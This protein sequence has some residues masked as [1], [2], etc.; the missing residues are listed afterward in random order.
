LQLEQKITQ[1]EQEKE[2][3][4]NQLIHAQKIESLGRLAGG[5]AHDF[6][7]ILTGI[8]G[9]SELALMQLDKDNPVTNDVKAIHK[10]GKRAE[11]LTRQL[12]TFSRKQVL[13]KK[14]VNLNLLVE[15]LVK[16]LTRMIGADILL[17][18]NLLNNLPNIFADTGQ[19]EQ[20]IM[21]LAVNARD[22]MP[23]GGKL[24]IETSESALTADDVKDIK[25]M[26]PG[27]YLLLTVKDNGKGMNQEIMEKIFEP[28]FTTKEVG[29][30]TGL[31]MSTVFGIIKQHQGHIKIDSEPNKGTTF[32]I[33]LPITSDIASHM[34]I[35]ENIQASGG[36]ETIMVVDDDHMTKKVLEDTLLS[37]GYTVFAALSGDESLTIARDKAV[38]IHLLITDIIMP[39]TNGKELAEHFKNIYPHLKILFISG[40]SDNIITSLGIAPDKSL[41][42]L[43]KPISPTVLAQKI[44]TLLDR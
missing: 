12:L 8:I 31:G 16:M 24:I 13:F 38:D 39:G 20:V 30:G 3:L 7:N 43:Q 37:L 28:F 33:F 41:S 29:E 34:S 36:T 2:G 18:L 23:E 10:A 32:Q 22:A 11:D 4:Q 21:N 5:I 1:A 27:P 35:I 6:N 40:Y 26:E 15:D 42:F 14:P 25:N 17:E 9:Y 19:I 44:R